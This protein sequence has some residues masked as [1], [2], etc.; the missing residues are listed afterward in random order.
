MARKQKKT[1]F[2]NENL[3]NGIASITNEVI[4]FKWFRLEYV[5]ITSHYRGHSLHEIAQSISFSFKLKITKH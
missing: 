1:G 4:R 5:F 2:D 3:G